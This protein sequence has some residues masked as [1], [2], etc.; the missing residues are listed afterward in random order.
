MYEPNEDQSNDLA[1]ELDGKIVELN[2]ANGKN[3]YCAAPGWTYA[4][5]NGSYENTS[6]DVRR[7]RI[8]RVDKNMIEW[9][10]VGD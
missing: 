9:E 4:C 2:L 3:V 6:D 10:L 8:I 1:S 5:M 7:W